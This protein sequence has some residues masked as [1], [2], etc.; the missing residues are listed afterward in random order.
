MAASLSHLRGTLFG[1]SM[2]FLRGSVKS[3]KA[4]EPLRLSLRHKQG[5]LIWLTEKSGSSI[6][7]SCQ[8]VGVQLDMVYPNTPEI[9]AGGCL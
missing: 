6:A 8:F 4:E 2:W 7:F 3:L 1:L 9:E 5:V